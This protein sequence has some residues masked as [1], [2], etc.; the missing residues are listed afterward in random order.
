MGHLPQGHPAPADEAG[1]LVEAELGLHFLSLRQSHLHKK[2][3]FVRGE[4]SES[5]LSLLA[6]RLAGGSEFSLH[7][8]LRLTRQLC[9]PKTP[10]KNTV[11][12]KLNSA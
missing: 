5:D 9:G 6:N 11:S 3:S 2:H 8:L 12:L 7:F 4:I 10:N 1:L